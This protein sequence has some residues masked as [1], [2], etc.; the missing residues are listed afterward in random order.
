[1]NEKILVIRPAWRRE[2][3]GIL[4]LA[5]LV[6]CIITVELLLSFLTTPLIQ[7]Q[8]TFQKRIDFEFYCRAVLTIIILIT[9]IRIMFRHYQNKYRITKDGVAH[10]IGI[11]GREERPLLFNKM[12]FATKKQSVFEYLFNIGT[13]NLFS[14]GTD[15]AD[16]ILTG[17]PSPKKLLDLINSRIDEESNT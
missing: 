5:V 2:W 16:V 14:S 15:K 7:I 4:L 3:V 12:T 11:L 10:I 1:V 17:V 6:F 9:A 13:V 8:T